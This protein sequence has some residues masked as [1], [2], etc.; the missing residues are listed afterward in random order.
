[1][2]TA[3]WRE[4]PPSVQGIGPVIGAVALTLPPTHS[5]G[6]VMDGRREPPQTNTLTS[7][8]HRHVLVDVFRGVDKTTDHP[9]P[10]RTVPSSNEILYYCTTFGNTINISFI[11][12]NKCTLF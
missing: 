4:K 7:A 11:Y 10:K 12:T 5:W 6:S 9:S 1:M 2:C 8:I 3:S